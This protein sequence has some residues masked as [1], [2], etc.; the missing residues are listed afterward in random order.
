MRKGYRLSEAAEMDI[1]AIWAYL[2]DVAGSART[3][4][5]VTD[6]ILDA[7]VFLAESPLAGHVRE[8]LAAPSLR[9]WTVTSDVIA[10]KCESDMIEIHRVLHL[11]RDLSAVLKP[12]EL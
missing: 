8:D 6:Q 11:A 1:A 5:R 2:E 12:N 3:A 7:L 10:Y 9:F 4:N